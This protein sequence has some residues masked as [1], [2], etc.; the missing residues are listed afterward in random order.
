MSTQWFDGEGIPTNDVGAT[1]DYY[2]NLSNADIYKKVYTSWQRIGNIR[3]SQGQ[4][5]E[6]G[7]RGDRGLK[8]DRGATG[9][10]GARGPEGPV[11]KQGAMWHDGIGV[12][13]LNLGVLNDMYLNIY[14]GDIYKKKGNSYWERVSCFLPDLQYLEDRVDAMVLRGDNHVAQIRAE[15]DA[16]QIAWKKDL[17]DYKDL[18]SEELDTRFNDLNTWLQNE[19]ASARI[20]MKGNVYETLGERLANDFTNDFQEVASIP[21]DVDAISNSGIFK[22]SNDEKMP[23]L[24]NFIIMNNQFDAKNQVQIAYSISKDN[25][26]CYIRDK[27]DGTWSSWHSNA[28]NMNYDTTLASINEN[29]NKLK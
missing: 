24:E 14:N 18:K 17:D 12:P 22:V 2:L 21:N 8:G 1:G 27:V 28:I 29:I 10:Q 26:S 19:L 11:G 3:G 4:Q 5:G 20:D 13:E 15:F 25:V 7:E 6:K 23:S 16:N 9:P